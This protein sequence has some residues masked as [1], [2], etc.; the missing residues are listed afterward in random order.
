MMTDAP[1]PSKRPLGWPV[2]TDA[3]EPFIHPGGD[4]DFES[5]FSAGAFSYVGNGYLTLRMDRRAEIPEGEASAVARVLELPWGRF[6]H[7]P[8]NSGK[9][10]AL[11][12]AAGALWR[13]G[14]KPIWERTV[15][16]YHLRPVPAVRVGTCVIAPLPL[17]QLLARLPRSRVWVSNTATDPL[18]CRWNGGEAMVAPL[19]DY[20]LGRLKEDFRILM[21]RMDAVDGGIRYAQDKPAKPVRESVPSRIIEDLSESVIIVRED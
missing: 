17:V 10:V 6:E 4:A 18:F 9:W 5:A 15:K 8:A 16:R 7:M 14:P 2:S 21:P 12:D 19:P 11:D 13:Y 1:E 20:A 3:L